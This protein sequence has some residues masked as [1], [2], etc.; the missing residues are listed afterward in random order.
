MPFDDKK[1]KVWCPGKM[2]HLHIANRMH[3]SA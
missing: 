2:M 1:S 3:A